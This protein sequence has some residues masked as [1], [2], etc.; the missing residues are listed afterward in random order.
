M[1]NSL[2]AM[3]LNGH[4]KR[5]GKQLE[6]LNS[7]GTDAIQAKACFPKNNRLHR[8]SAVP[9]LLGA[10]SIAAVQQRYSP[11]KSS[12]VTW[13]HDILKTSRRCNSVKV[14]GL[15]EPTSPGCNLKRCHVGANFGGETLSLPSFTGWVGVAFR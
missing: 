8:S 15:A 12:H 3:I 7:F 2:A 5:M 9:K 10:F 4:C 14:A 13:I 6:A 11:L 1:Y